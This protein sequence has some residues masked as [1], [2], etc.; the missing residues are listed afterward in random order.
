M[1]KW[2]ARSWG[3]FLLEIFPA[4]D[5]YLHWNKLTIA[6][7]NEEI[8]GPSATSS[9]DSLTDSISQEQVVPLQKYE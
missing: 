6:G 7:Q 8:R 3:A 4:R 9:A 2:A 5:G 1:A